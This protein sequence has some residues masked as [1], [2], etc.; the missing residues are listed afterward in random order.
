MSTEITTR[1][2]VLKVYENHRLQATMEIV[3][4]TELGRREPNEPGPFARM[5]RGTSDRII[6]AELDEK[7]VSRKHLYVELNDDRSICL[8]NQSSK[9]TLALGGGVRLEPGERKS[10]D[11]P[12]TCEIGRKVVRLEAAPV[13]ELNLQSLREPTLAP[14]QSSLAIDTSGFSSLVNELRGGEAGRVR[15][16]DLLAWLQT[17][18]DVFQSAATSA[19]FLPKAAHAAGQLVGL[20]TAAVLL[21]RDANWSTATVSSRDRDVAADNWRASQSMLKRVVVERRTFFHVPTQTGSSARSLLGVQSL[22]AAPILDRNSQV[23]GAFYGER[24]MGGAHAGT[25]P[26]GEIEAKLFELLACGIAAGLARVDQERQLI[27]ERVRFEQFFTPELARMLQSHGEAMLAARD[28][29][30][31]VLFCD[32]KGFSRISAQINAALVIEWVRDVLSVLSDCVAEQQ[33]VLVDY[34]GDSVEALWG[35]PLATP[36]HAIQACQAAIAMRASLG[37]INERWQSRL[38]EKTDISIGIHS[39]QAQVG[40]IGSRRKFKYGALGTTVNQASRIQGTTKQVGVSFL[41]THATAALLD[42]RFPLRRLCSLRT[43][44]IPEPVVVYELADAPDARWS[45]LKRRY[46][47]A[48]T[49]FE[50]GKFYEAM[51]ILG[52]LMA[53]FPHDEPTRYLLQRNVNYLN[54]SSGDFDPVWNLER[55]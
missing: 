50:S 12:V 6:L 55:K 29:V 17:S 46:E 43:V 33:G 54:K 3:R 19:D 47:D 8:T 38:G 31:T 25:P 34:S 53:E 9:N 42:S 13:E 23:I 30:I 35:A 16:T 39:G 40:N 22:V 7:S 10:F 21:R 28:A 20:D 45:E 24:R 36:Q 26:I 49:L 1:D 18:M 14:G 52:G 41:V 5:D 37:E 44:N 48:L 15:K 11:L 4:A 2:I 27:A 32:I 51:A